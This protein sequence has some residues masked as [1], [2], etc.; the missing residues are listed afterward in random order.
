MEILENW[1]QWLGASGG[2]AVVMLYAA[3]LMWTRS[4]SGPAK[5]KPA[6]ANCPDCGGKVSSKIKACPHCGRP[7][8]G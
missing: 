1:R 8:D 4:Q 5:P 2:L 3:Y 6:V 7:M